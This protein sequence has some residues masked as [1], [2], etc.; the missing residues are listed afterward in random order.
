MATKVG[1]GMACLEFGAST[2]WIYVRSHRAVGW[3]VRIALP[4]PRLATVSSA[5]TASTAFSIAAGPTRRQI[6]WER[7]KVL[8]LFLLQHN[9]RIVIQVDKII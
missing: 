9:C 5:G 7:L 4:L 1:G 3:L 8:T 2:L 6:A